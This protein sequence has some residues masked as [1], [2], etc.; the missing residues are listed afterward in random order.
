MNINKRS[1]CNQSVTCLL[2]QFSVSSLDCTDFPSVISSAINILL[3]EFEFACDPAF[4]IMSRTSWPSVNQVTGP[5][6]YIMD[7]IKSADQVIDTIKPLVD[8]KKYLRNLL[9]KACRLAQLNICEILLTP[10]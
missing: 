1:L 9:D 5:S 6:P 4:L 3:R 2:G 7:L 8:Q 10:F